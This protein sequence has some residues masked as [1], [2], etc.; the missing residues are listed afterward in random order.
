MKGIFIL[1]LICIGAFAYP[2]L[3]ENKR[4]LR[5][6]HKSTASDEDGSTEWDLTA[7]E[8]ALNHI[9]AELE[10]EDDELDLLQDLDEGGD[11]IDESDYSFKY[12]KSDGYQ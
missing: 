12:W 3:L 5:T 6:N 8:E 9:H 7:E 10:W 1:T 11:E 2:S 4:E